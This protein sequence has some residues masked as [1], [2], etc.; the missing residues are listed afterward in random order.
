[1]IVV[2][3]MRMIMMVMK[4]RVKIYPPEQGVHP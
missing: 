1:M 2:I 4:V 3:M